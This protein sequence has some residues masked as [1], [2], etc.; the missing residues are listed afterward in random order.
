MYKVRPGQNETKVRTV[1]NSICHF[2]AYTMNMNEIIFIRN[3]SPS[4]VIKLFYLKKLF[5][6]YLDYVLIKNI[7]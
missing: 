6:P 7:D 4:F 2:K 3:E 1:K 5:C